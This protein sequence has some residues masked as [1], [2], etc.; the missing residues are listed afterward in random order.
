MI[1]EY[2]LQPSVLCSWAANRR[3]YAEFMREYGLGTPRI[4]SS[5]PKRKASKL[6]SYFLQ[7][8]PGDDQSLQGLRYTEMVDRLVETLVLREPLG[9]LPGDWAEAAISE[10]ARAPFGVLISE[11][12]LETEK[13][14]TPG[15]MY[16]PGSIWNHPNQ[17]DFQRTRAAFYS[18]IE[19]MVRLAS[20]CVI[21]IDAY[22]WT[23]DSITMLQNIINSMHQGRMRP[24]FPPVSL[25]YKEGKAS[26][27]AQYV[28]E[29][30]AK[31]LNVDGQEI[32]FGVFAL[33]EI[34]GN[35]VFHNRCILTELGGIMIGHGIGVTDDPSH[36]DDATLMQPSIYSKKWRQFIDERCF[37]VVSQA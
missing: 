3:D 29:H 32:D 18:V 7:H 21:I 26:P 4:I 35:D 25:Y 24:K 27:D 12:P 10:N 23:N 15:C 2:A 31:G 19:N 28:K 37:D 30:V 1:H 14:V 17:I 9:N 36:T 6:R 34:P 33:R 5:F 22:G 8:S 16:D 13:N 20:G 11:M